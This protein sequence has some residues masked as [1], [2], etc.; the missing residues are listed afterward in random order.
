[1]GARVI[2]HVEYAALFA[3][4]VVLAV[5]QRD[6]LSPWL[7][8]PLLLAPDVLGYVP[9]LLMGAAPEKGALPPSG[10]WLYNL[11]HTYTVPLAIGAALTVATGAVPWWILGWPLHITLDRALGFGL[12]GPDGRQG[13]L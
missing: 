1:M 5:W 12:R 13:V 11:W 2:H 6:Q 9:A 8:W 4:L 7:F 10:V 3:V